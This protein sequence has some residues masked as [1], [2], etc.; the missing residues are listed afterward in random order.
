MPL[1][2]TIFAGARQT[3]LSYLRHPFLWDRYPPPYGAD[4]SEVAGQFGA[5]TIV[6]VGPPPSLAGLGFQFRILRTYAVS[7]SNGVVPEILSIYRQADYKTVSRL[8]AELEQSVIA[9]RLLI[10]MSAFRLLC[11]EQRCVVLIER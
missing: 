2:S 8:D 9:Q 10:D 11:H 6:V 7:G 3:P 4:G 1:Y 5:S